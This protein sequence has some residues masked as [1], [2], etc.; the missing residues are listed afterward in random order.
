M[1]QGQVFN[2]MAWLPGYEDEY[3]TG[4]EQGQ[5]ANFTSH[6]FFRA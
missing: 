1:Q 3:I 4:F 5:G 2:G 6:K